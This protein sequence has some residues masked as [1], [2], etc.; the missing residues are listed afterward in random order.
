MSDATATEGGPDSVR[1]GI[2]KAYD[3]R[4]VYGEEMDG[5][6]AYLI[7]RAFARVLADLLG[8]VAVDLVAVQAADVVGL[9]DAG[10]D[11]HRARQRS[12]RHPR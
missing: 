2:F 3:V 10:V 7:G 11:R 5:A 6:T 12:Y 9:E 8:G 4:G 1:A